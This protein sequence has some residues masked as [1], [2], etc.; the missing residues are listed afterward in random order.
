MKDGR[1]HLYSIS[2]YKEYM[3][4]IISLSILTLLIIGT[5]VWLIYRTLKEG[6]KGLDEIKKNN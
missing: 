1:K 3:N 4:T 2:I 5:T 6:Y